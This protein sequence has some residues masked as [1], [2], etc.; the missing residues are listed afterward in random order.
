MN[1]NNTTR[2]IG[3]CTRNRSN[4]TAD[5]ESQLCCNRHSSACIVRRR[6]YMLGSRALAVLLAIATVLASSDCES[7]CAPGGSCALAYKQQPG[8]C[9]GNLGSSSFCC[10]MYGKCFRCKGGEY[11][12]FSASSPEPACT[13]CDGLGGDPRAKC[14]RSGALGGESSVS[15]V[16]GIIVIAIILFGCCKG[17]QRESIH[18]HYA[19]AVEMPSAYQPPMQPAY[20]QPMGYAQPPMGQPVQPSVVYQ[21]PEP[22]G[23]SGGTVAAAAGAGFLGG[24]LAEHVI[25][26][27]GD[28]GGD[29]G[30]NHGD[31]GGG[32]AGFAADSGGDGGGGGDEGFDA[33]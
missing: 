31:M 7:C 27:H 15:F 5:F 16:F 23:Y 2:Y 3:T 30:G 25:G 29:G 1:V 22:H 28:M 14:T 32:D 21:Q 9:C 11:R 24:M 19:A 6:P 20:G 12:C 18:G 17:I 13:I 10:P 4:E 26:N 8:I 33:E